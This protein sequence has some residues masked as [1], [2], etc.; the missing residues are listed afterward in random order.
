MYLYVELWKA[1]PEWLAL[2]QQERGEYM[3][4]VGPAIDYLDFLSIVFAR[5]YRDAL[6]E[7]TLLL[8]SLSPDLRRGV[9]RGGYPPDIPWADTIFILEHSPDPGQRR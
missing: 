8:R 4:N 3:A 2:S 6:R 7:H 5:R 1:K 9:F